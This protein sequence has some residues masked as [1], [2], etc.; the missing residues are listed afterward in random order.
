MHFS[1]IEFIS[2]QGLKVGFTL[3]LMLRTALSPMPSRLPVRAAR[4]QR[5]MG[6]PEKTIMGGSY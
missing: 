2:P 1:K 3:V 4:W 5:R 6:I